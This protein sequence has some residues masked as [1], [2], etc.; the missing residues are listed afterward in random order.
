MLKWLVGDPVE[1]PPARG[2]MSQS[3]SLSIPT[4]GLSL[5]LHRRT[6][7]P[8]VEGGT[9]M[10]ECTKPNYAA[11]TSSDSHPINRWLVMITSFGDSYV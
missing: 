8:L 2:V 10:A 7:G 4:N 5:T 9:G 3:T 11:V 6:T 1:M